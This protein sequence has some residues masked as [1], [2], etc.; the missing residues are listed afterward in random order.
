MPEGAGVFLKKKKKK[1][2]PFWVLGAWIKT[3]GLGGGSLTL[4]GLRAGEF[5]ASWFTNG[6]RGSRSAPEGGEQRAVPAR[7]AGASGSRSCLSELRG[8]VLRRGAGAPGSAC[9]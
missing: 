3:R 5:Q 2:G 7:W 6:R 9:L 1:Y 4:E 8:L